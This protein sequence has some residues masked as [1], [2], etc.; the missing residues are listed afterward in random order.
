MAKPKRRKKD[1]S[2]MVAL[3]IGIWLGII[4]LIV[5]KL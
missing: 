4:A 2:A 5:E 1:H 3:G